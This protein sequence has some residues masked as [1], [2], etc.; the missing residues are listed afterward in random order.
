MQ[1]NFE[2]IRLSSATILLGNLTLKLPI[3]TIA[4]CFVICLWFLKS[5]FANSV[6]QDQTAPLRAVWS[7][8]T[9]FAGMQK[10]GLKSL[11]DIKQRT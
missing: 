1:N 7:G 11:Q 4:I 5:F 10:I 3:T 9:L 8:S 2:K 6:D